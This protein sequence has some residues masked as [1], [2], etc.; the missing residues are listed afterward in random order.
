MGRSGFTQLELLVALT[1]V[2]L[3]SVVGLSA[4]QRA[5]E[6]SRRTQCTSNL[7][8]I[9]LA[10]H[11][12]QEQDG[13]FAAS[14]SQPYY[15]LAQGMGLSSRFSDSRLPAGERVLHCP[16]DL[17][18]TVFLS[19]SYRLNNGLIFHEHSQYQGWGGGYV[20]EGRRPADFTDGLSVSAAYAE[21]LL[22]PRGSL[23][24]LQRYPERLPWWTQQRIEPHADHRAQFVEECLNRRTSPF[25]RAVIMPGID[26][27]DIYDH[28]LPPNRIGCWNG[29]P[30]D[31][32][33]HDPQLL[34]ASSLHAGGVNVLF[35]DGHVSFVS[36]SVAIEVWQAL[37]TIA[38][39][40]PVSGAY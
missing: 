40:E 21:K 35:A 19:M 28:T 18:G 13:L 15:D 25:P 6:T 23:E 4:V 16:S 24:I 37:G 1:I 10:M 26:V 17:E 8:R 22:M 27:N 36:N 30:E 5:R 20:G 32:G 38:G 12:F 7:R 34:P 33:P 31:W 9:G 39:E 11:N 2:G 14:L 29:P 3:L